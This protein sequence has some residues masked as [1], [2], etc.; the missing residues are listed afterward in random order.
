MSTEVATGVAVAVMVLSNAVVGIGLLRTAARTRR[1]PELLIGLG[2]FG[3]GPVS[4]G[5]TAFAGTGRLPCGEV[6]TLLHA[7]GTLGSG[8]GMACIYG[9]VLTV[10][11]PGVAWARA[12]TAA[13]VVALAVSGAG[14][15]L[16][17]AQ[18]AP[19]VPSQQVLQSW[20]SAVLALFTGAFGWAALESGAYYLRAR[21]RLRIG[22]IDAAVTNRF[23][24]WAVAS[25]SC[26]VLGL[27][28][29]DIQLDG[30]QLA[31]SLV[32]SLLIMGV[33]LLTGASMYLAFLPPRAY[34]AWLQRRAPTAAA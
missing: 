4:Q 3:M 11:R 33:S 24:L 14:A 34:L 2:L 20:G 9:F 13:A 31:G 29:L 27:F 28:L 16:A 21:K 7:L 18:A 23:L 5:L 30:R 8:I 1:K 25:G 6:N 26:F 22:L 12:V 15:V 32:P 19:E 17:V 10:F